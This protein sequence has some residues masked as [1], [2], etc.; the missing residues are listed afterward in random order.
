MH[1]G[2]GGGQRSFRPRG[3]RLPT[4]RPLKG[5]CMTVHTGRVHAVIIRGKDVEG[6]SFEQPSPSSFD[7]LINKKSPKENP[8]R[9]P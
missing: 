7:A 2:C 4:R 9:K 5:Y 8:G 3:H 1:K 6:L